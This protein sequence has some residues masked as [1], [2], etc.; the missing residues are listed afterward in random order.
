M[1]KGLCRVANANI[2]HPVEV[3]SFL[4]VANV[5][6]LFEDSCLGQKSILPTSFSRLYFA[7]AALENSICSPKP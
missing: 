2:G 1:L 7:R 5:W 6:Q 3:V 4:S